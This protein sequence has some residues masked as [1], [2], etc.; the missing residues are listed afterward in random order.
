MQVGIFALSAFVSLAAS[1]VLV[2]RLARVGERLGLSEAMLGLLAALAADGP[3]ITAAIAAIAGGHTTEGI[4]VALGSNVFI[5]AAL[6]GVSV[7]IVGRI[8]FQRRAVLLEGG[9]GLWIALL[10]LAVVAGVAGPAVGLVLVLLA[11]TAPRRG[12]TGNCAYDRR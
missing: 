8:D 3:N 7:L 10:A 5:L 4:G 1:A 11:R 9:L 2:V 12:R 6:L